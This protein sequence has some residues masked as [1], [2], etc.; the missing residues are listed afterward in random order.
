M[1]HKTRYSVRAG[2]AYSDCVV[3]EKKM[4]SVFLFQVHASGKDI[5]LLFSP[6]R[7][8]STLEC[9]AIASLRSATEAAAAHARVSA[10][11]IFS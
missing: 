9:M 8:D 6:Y 1:T 10:V 7:A 5:L 4:N 2:P 3:H 11:A